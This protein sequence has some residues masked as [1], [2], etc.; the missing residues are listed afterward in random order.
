VLPS[1]S[2]DSDS[3]ERDEA[4]HV[5][6]AA[7]SRSAPEDAEEAAVGAGDPP[8]APDAGSS[9]E[10]SVAD[11]SLAEPADRD[12]TPRPAVEAAVE[13]GEPAGALGD[14]FEQ[15][16]GADEVTPERSDAPALAPV[17]GA[18]PDF[19]QQR[20]REIAEEIGMQVL[21]RI[22]IFT[23]TTLRAQLGERLRPAVDRAASDIV[24]AINEHVGE[25][26]RAQ[27]SE[28][29]ER[30]IESWKRSR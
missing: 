18:I 11:R 13:S 12:P 23:D 27:V 8:V 28:A 5:F 21:Q 20:I 22:D 19:E 9:F 3:P 7:V 6:S 2:D 29:I 24:A 1:S 16:A 15:G 4:E 17:Q 14:A 10:D 30:E 25:L 26:L